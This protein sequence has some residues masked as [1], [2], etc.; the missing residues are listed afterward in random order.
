[1][2]N[3]F[4]T[5]EE[6]LHSF[7][8]SPLKYLSHIYDL[9]NYSLPQHLTFLPNL[10]LYLSSAEIIVVFYTDNKDYYLLSFSIKTYT[11]S[12]LK[13][14]IFTKG[15]QTFPFA[16][17]TSVISNSR[18]NNQLCLYSIKTNAMA[19]IDDFSMMLESKNQS[20]TFQCET[21][22]KKDIA[23]SIKYSP[24]DNYIGILL[25]NNTLILF[26]VE[27]MSQVFSYAIQSGN[28]VKDFSFQVE[29]TFPSANS[30]TFGMGEVTV[31]ENGEAKVLYVEAAT[32]GNLN[33]RMEPK[34]FKKNVKELHF[35][36]NAKY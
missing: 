29:E 16:E 26:S 4:K 24:F 27:L 28:S 14:I 34:T 22:S 6:Q 9:Q 21:L 15:K 5:I 19:V 20:I 3:N 35:G 25:S 10:T 7:F 23:I 17:I 8:V 18:N 2:L 33:K 13:R 32:T 30:I 31:K 11:P 12:P 36:E 1:M